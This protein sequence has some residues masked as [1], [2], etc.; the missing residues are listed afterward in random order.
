MNFDD[1]AGYDASKGVLADID[2][3]FGTKG[4]RLFYLAV[5]PEYF[6]DIIGFLGKAGMAKPT[7]GSW[8]RTIIEKPFGHDLK[9]AQRSQRRGQ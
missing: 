6:S 2:K 4:N 3:K 9:S 8:T 1:A 5:A 7:E